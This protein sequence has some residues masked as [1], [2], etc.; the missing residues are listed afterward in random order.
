MEKECEHI[1]NSKQVSP[2]TVS[3]EECQKEHLPVTVR[4]CL[5]CGYVGCC[6]S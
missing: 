2:K 6:D 5:T 4:M 1:P 3:C